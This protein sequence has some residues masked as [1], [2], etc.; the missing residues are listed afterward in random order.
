MVHPPKIAMTLTPE[1][2]GFRAGGVVGVMAG[3]GDMVG[4]WFAVGAG[5]AGGVGVG[6]GRV[7]V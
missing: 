2:S 1:F 6:L 3:A 7:E 4:L 5:A